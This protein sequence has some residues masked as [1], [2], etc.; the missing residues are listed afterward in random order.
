MS[1]CFRYF[2]LLTRR[3]LP[4]VVLGYK[5]RN[6]YALFVT[7][8]IR[9]PLRSYAVTHFISDRGRTV[10]AQIYGVGEFGENAH[11]VRY[12]TI[13]YDTTYTCF[14]MYTHLTF[15]Q[16]HA[17]YRTC[18]TCIHTHECEQTFHLNL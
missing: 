5:V 18:I 8:F 17:I 11:N 14:T 9:R 16:N 2:S 1:C 6:C 13:Q 4:V 15:A 12:D 7:H 10:W 3:T